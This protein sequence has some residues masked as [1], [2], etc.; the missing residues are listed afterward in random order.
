MR[1]SFVCLLLAAVIAGLAVFRSPSALAQSG[2]WTTKTPMPEAR[3]QSASAAFGG[4]FYIFGGSSSTVPEVYDPLS[5][6]WSTRAPDSTARCDMAAITYNGKIHVIGGSIN[7]DFNS[8]TTV[9]RVYDPV[10]NTWSGAAS[11][12]V[13]RGETASGLIG[14]KFYL[15]GGGASFPGAVNQ[16]EIYDPGAERQRAPT[17]TASRFSPASSRQHLPLRLSRSPRKET[18]SSRSRLIRATGR[19][20]FSLATQMVAIRRSSHISVRTSPPPSRPTARR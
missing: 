3:E 20:R 11:T 17:L 12:L 19:A 18:A 14:G 5:N 4:L 9:H 8:P 13:A 16:T 10:A 7:C 6:N 2:S 1:R 15:T